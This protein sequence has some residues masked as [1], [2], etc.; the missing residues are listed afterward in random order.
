M[1]ETTKSQIGKSDIGDETMTQQDLIDYAWSIIANAGGGDW[2]KETEE[3][4]GAAEKWRDQYFE[5]LQSQDA[6]VERTVNG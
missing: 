2:S 3:W 4:R 1:E 6:S 5:L